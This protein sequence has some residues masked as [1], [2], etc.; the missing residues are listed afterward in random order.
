MPF[1][2]VSDNQDVYRG[3]RNL[4]LL[5]QNDGWPFIS[6]VTIWDDGRY[7][8]DMYV[9]GAERKHFRKDQVEMILEVDKLLKELPVTTNDA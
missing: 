9:L 2:I 1:E 4:R 7:E 6:D 3:S 8:V 5:N